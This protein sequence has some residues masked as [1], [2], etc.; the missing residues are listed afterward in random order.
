M[1]NDRVV[2]QLTITV[3]C[4]GKPAVVVSPPGAGTG[5]VCVVEPPGGG[6][7]TGSTTVPGTGTTTP[8]AASATAAAQRTVHIVAGNGG[9]AWFTLLWP[10]PEV[11]LSANPQHALDDRSH[12]GAVPGTAVEHPL[13]VRRVGPRLLWKV[14]AGARNRRSSWRARTR[15]TPTRRR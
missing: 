1:S 9:L 12:F 8:P 14:R 3:D 6:G 13:H 2:I 10:V 7:S 4:D 15:P 5:T 11:A